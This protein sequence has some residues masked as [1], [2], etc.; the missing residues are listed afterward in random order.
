MYK[1]SY[2]EHSLQTVS[3]AERRGDRIRIFSYGVNSDWDTDVSASFIL[4]HE[5]G[6]LF[7]IPEMYQR[8]PVGHSNSG[9]MVCMMQR[10]EHERAE[11]FYDLIRKNIYD[12]ITDENIIDAFC[13]VCW[14][15]LIDNV[16]LS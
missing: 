9:P 3:L 1:N 11:E 13:D 12:N 16:D 6:H 8:D 4:A 2:G 10:Y 7:G 14:G 5:I 15:M